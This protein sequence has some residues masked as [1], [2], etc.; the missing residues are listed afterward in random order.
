MS[1][2]KDIYYIY[3]IYIWYKICACYICTYISCTYFIYKCINVI[4]MIFIYY[5]YILLCTYFV[6]MDWGSLEWF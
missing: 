6:Y 5:M 1:K 2:A 4:Y 3:H